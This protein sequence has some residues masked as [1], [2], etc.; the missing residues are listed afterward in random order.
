M[1][2]FTWA[3]LP[4]FFAR[5]TAV[6]A[7]VRVAYVNSKSATAPRTMWVVSFPAMLIPVFSAT[8]LAQTSREIDAHQFST[9]T[10]SSDYQPSDENASHSAASPQG[11]SSQN[12]TNCSNSC[13]PIDWVHA[14]MRKVEWTRHVPVSRITSPP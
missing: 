6:L 9:S 4:A 8:L 13:Q 14:W 2:W 12:D 5:L 10:F 3:V 1:K 7:K 11:D